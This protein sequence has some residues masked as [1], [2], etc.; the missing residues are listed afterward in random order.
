MD[1]KEKQ[2][3][4][5]AYVP[6]LHK[7]YLDHLIDKYSE[8]ENVALIGSSEF[9]DCINSSLSEND[10]LYALIR[11]PRCVEPGTMVR[12]LKAIFPKR[13]FYVFGENESGEFDIKGFFDS[14]DRIVM[15]DEDISHKIVE[16]YEI[17]L[18]KVEFVKCWVRW[19]MPRSTSKIDPK[20]AE[21]TTSDLLHR[22]MMDLAQ[23]GAF[24]SPDFWRQVGA[25]LIKDG[26]P[27]MWGF[28]QH[29]P[30][31]MEVYFSGDP[32]SN[33]QAGQYIEHSVA[34]HGEATMIAKAA[35][36]GIETD[37]SSMYVTVFPCPPCAYAIMNAGIKTLY[38][39][40]GYSLV[41][42]AEKLREAGVEIIRVV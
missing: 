9:I 41:E 12:V 25:V 39:R 8:I 13:Y 21:I 28:N 32:R 38:F 11:D 17:N 42:S 33:F 7:G 14:Q 31:N 22:E 27:V 35:R 15:P 29:V 19:D 40:E 6:V 26:K 36:Q 1:S 20:A 4:I 30:H 3:L 37:G 23:E 10:K 2:E 34:E 24:N 18:E 5:L 16:M